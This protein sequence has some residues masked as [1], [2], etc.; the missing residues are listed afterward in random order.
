MPMMTDPG[1]DT[2]FYSSADVNIPVGIVHKVTGE[3]IPDFFYKNIAKPMQ[4]Q[5]YYMNLMPTGEAYMGG[6]LYIRPRDFIKLGQ[7]YLDG[8]KWNGRQIVS[9][10]WVDES[11]KFAAHFKPAFDQDSGH[12]YG[13]G[14]HKRYL[15]INGKKARFY[16]MGGNG[17]QCTIVIP[18][19]DMV[20]GTTGGDYGEL[21][22]FFLWE[23]EDIP[24]YIVPAVM[25]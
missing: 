22:K 20:I 13:F 17:G 4:M 19:L 8:G 3:W 7:V 25:K 12:D 1:R 5:S 23:I 10:K 16:Y 24:K 18:A 2:A 9:R 21:R 6:G 15:D 14:W 11:F